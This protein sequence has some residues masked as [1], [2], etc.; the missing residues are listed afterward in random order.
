MTAGARYNRALHEGGIPAVSVNG[1]RATSSAQTPAIAANESA[2]FEIAQTH[3]AILFARMASALSRKN[4]SSTSPTGF[5]GRVLVS[6]NR[7]TRG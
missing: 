5:R 4:V 2:I 6:A 1:A 3:A 7:V